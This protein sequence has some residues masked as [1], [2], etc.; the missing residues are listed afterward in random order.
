MHEVLEAFSGLG[1]LCNVRST[2]FMKGYL[3]RA[4][5]VEKV[6]KVKWVTSLVSLWNMLSI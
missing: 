4:E 6:E 3:L 1:G 5:K 2:I